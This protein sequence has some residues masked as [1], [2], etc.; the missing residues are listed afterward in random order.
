MKCLVFLAMVM[1]LAGVGRA[2]GQS[3]AEEKGAWRASS[4]TAQSITGDVFFGGDKMS[5]NFNAFIIA[6]IRDLQ[7]EEIKAA[8]DLDANPKSGGRLYRLDI[9]ASK[10]FVHKNAI[11]TGEDTQWMVSYV[12]GKSLM[13]AFFLG[14]PMPVLKSEQMANATNLC[15]TFTYAR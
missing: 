6:E 7:P 12:D 5:I 2:V 9:P 3:S 8:F 4:K 13:L 10:K 15:G 14:T 1:C 11:C